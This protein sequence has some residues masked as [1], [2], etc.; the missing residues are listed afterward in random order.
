MRAGRGNA[1]K[2]AEK[3]QFLTERVRA[4]SVARVD[5]LLTPSPVAIVSGTMAR[6]AHTDREPVDALVDRI[7]T[8][9][10][11][12]DGSVLFPEQKLWTQENFHGLVERFNDN[13]LTDGRSFEEKLREQLDESP[14]ELVRLMAD[15]VAFH[16]LFVTSV[17]GRRKR[18]LVTDVLEIA[19]DSYPEKQDVDKAFD[20]GIGSGGQGFNTGRP[21]LLQYLISFG[22]RFKDLAQSERE[23]LLDDATAFTRWLTGPNGDADGGEQMMRHV[24]LHLLFP[25]RFERIS[26]QD[27]KYLIVNSLGGLVQGDLDEDVDNAL[28]QIRSALEEILPDGQPT[29][30]GAIDF[31]ETPLQ[32]TWDVD[33]VPSSE[34]GTERGL[35]SLQSLLH[36]KQVVL[37]G[38][39]GTGKTFEAKVLAERTL[40]YEALRRWGPVHYL[41]NEERVKELLDHQIRRLQLHQAYS[42]EDFVRG[43]RLTADGTEPHDGY[44]LR[45]VSEIEEDRTSCPDPSPLPWILILDELNRTD[46]SRLLGEV[47]SLLDDRDAAINLALADQAGRTEFQLP[48]DLL[49]VGT[50]NLIDQSVEELDFALRRRFLWLPTPFRAEMIVP[51]VESRWKA[52]D[53]DEFPWMGRH[54]WG[55]A[56]GDIEQLA[57]RA[58]RLNAEIVTSPLLGAQYEVGH[59]YLIDVVGLIARSPRI[60]AGRSHRGRYLWSSTGKPQPPLIDLWTHSLEPLLAEYLAGVAPDVRD[61]QLRKLR[62]TFLAPQ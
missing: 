23:R 57:E 11:V 58:K 42:Y 62:E 55:Y 51:I 60:Q 18:E 7:R 12:A 39:P 48:D 36:K 15:L 22:S 3:R 41:Q 52:L 2:N 47:F 20:T 59:T 24:L 29:I 49:L 8:E 45:L 19:G 61:D 53:V 9:C 1:R 33:L 54:S 56:I 34:G 40:R 46:V 32:E 4:V 38:P 31:Y 30:G 26:A 43:L 50:L 10:L 28:L 44:L 37:F 16:Y 35:S 25:E 17:S 14:A 27:D 5:T 13:P 21:F 6:F